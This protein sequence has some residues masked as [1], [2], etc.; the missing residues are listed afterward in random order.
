MVR[1]RAQKF[2]LIHIYL[3]SAATIAR[4]SS[5]SFDT[6]SCTG[7]ERSTSSF[8]CLILLAERDCRRLKP[9]TI[10]F[11]TS[12]AKIEIS[13][14]LI[15]APETNPLLAF[16]F[17]MLLPRVSKTSTAFSSPI[18]IPVVPALP[19]RELT[20]ETWN[21]KSSVDIFSIIPFKQ[22]QI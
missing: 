5:I 8:K 12:K 6:K 7:C 4:S 17:V 20:S 19:K 13:F 3:L 1:K 16:K 22:E 11:A 10:V 21:R 15:A 18:A 2:D 14:P 9:L